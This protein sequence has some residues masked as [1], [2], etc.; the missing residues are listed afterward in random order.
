MG[1]DS[2]IWGVL[3]VSCRLRV[4]SSR[5]LTSFSRICS[6]RSCASL[7]IA[8]A[9]NVSMNVY[10]QLKASDKVPPR[11]VLGEEVMLISFC[12]A[13]HASWRREEADA[14]VC[15]SVVVSGVIL[16]TPLSW[17]LTFYLMG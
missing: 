16:R 8:L 1:K 12:L 14:L 2:C 7:A 10:F 13:F 9:S 15:R 3:V 5:A 6:P 17:I 4:E 11:G